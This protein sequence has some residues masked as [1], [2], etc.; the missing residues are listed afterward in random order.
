MS[1]VYGCSVV[2]LLKSAEHGQLYAILRQKDELVYFREPLLTNC[3][4]FCKERPCD[5][6][7][8][9]TIR[10]LQCGYDIVENNI[11]TA[12]KRPRLRERGD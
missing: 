5:G 8:A 6:G 2:A 9:N 3:G 11:M 10:P 1:D 4:K 7:T 12:L